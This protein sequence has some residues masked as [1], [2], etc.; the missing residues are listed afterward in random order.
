MKRAF[1]ILLITV[2]F[3]PVSLSGLDLMK[4][5]NKLLDKDKKT[6]VEEKKDDVSADVPSGE[7]AKSGS[8]TAKGGF[9]LLIPNGWKVTQD[10]TNS[11]RLDA[12][13]HP[14]VAVSVVCNDYGKDFPVEASYKSYLQTAKDEKSK[15]TIENY[16]EITLGGAKGILRIENM[17]SDPDDPRRITFQGYAGTIGINIVAS[18]QGKLFKTYRQTLEEIVKSMKWN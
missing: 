10:E 4:N 1:F 2:L 15:N 5:M 3:F 16:K 13:S 9:T 7:P 18:S 8:Y 6:V 11:F 14:G 17:P 12:S